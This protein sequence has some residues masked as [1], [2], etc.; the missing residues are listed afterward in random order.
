MDSLQSPP[1]SEPKIC[2]NK[3]CIV[4]CDPQTLLLPSLVFFSV[5]QVSHGKWLLTLPSLVRSTTR[6]LW[7]GAFPMLR[8]EQAGWVM[9]GEIGVLAS[10]WLTWNPA[11]T[12]SLTYPL[13]PWDGGW[14]S[15]FSSF[16]VWNS[17][18]C[19][20]EVQIHLSRKNDGPTEKALLKSAPTSPWSLK[21]MKYTAQTRDLSLQVPPHLA[22]LFWIVPLS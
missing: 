17:S 2:Y 16:S 13:Q 8:W 18:V 10:P 11:R 12:P 5:C 15:R 3:N 22:I 6:H 9:A 7:S 21:Y 14:A 4:E 19:T 1:P 20:T